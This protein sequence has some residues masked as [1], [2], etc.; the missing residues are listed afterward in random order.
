MA[1]VTD[2]SAVSL[3]SEEGKDLLGAAGRRCLP[4]QNWSTPMRHRRKLAT[5]AVATVLTAALSACGSDDADDSSDA[6]SESTPS[7][8]DDETSDDEETDDPTDDATE[9]E[10]DDAATFDGELTEPGSDLALGDTATVPFDYA[11]NEGVIEITVVE[12]REGDPADVADVDGA[13]GM[14]PYHVTYEVTG[15]ESPENLGGMV[16][17]LDGLTA[18]GN[19]TSQLINFGNGVGGCDEESPDTDWDGS[20]FE[21]CD[22]FLSDQAVTQ[23]A[24]AEGDDY[25][26]WDDTQV[27]WS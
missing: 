13:E 4:E 16:I 1:Q 8:S 9:D 15:V 5:V 26:L 20:T 11:G 2:A 23:V 25:S 21:T 3:G 7:T 17:S 14:T 19:D 12:I 6:T 24:F 27:I 22:T 10:S 18:D